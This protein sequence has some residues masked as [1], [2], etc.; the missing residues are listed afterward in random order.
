MDD[1]DSL[2]DKIRDPFVF[3]YSGSTAVSVGVV[4]VVISEWCDEEEDLVVCYEKFLP[5]L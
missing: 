2:S 3:G 5:L 4:G 1:L